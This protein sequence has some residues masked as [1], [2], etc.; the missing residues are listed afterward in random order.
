MSKLFNGDSV[1]ITNYMDFSGSSS[2]SLDATASSVVG[3]L[4]R[5]SVTKS[6]DTNEPTVIVSGLR[7]GTNVSSGGDTL[8]G[9]AL[10]PSDSNEGVQALSSV[11]EILHTS[12][13]DLQ[14]DWTIEFERV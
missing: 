7:S 2:F 4:G 14:V 13:F 9:A 12:S 3:S 11:P 8:Y 5:V 1:A 6:R 10:L